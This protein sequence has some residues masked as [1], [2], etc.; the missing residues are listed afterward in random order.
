LQSIDHHVRLYLET[1]DQRHLEMAQRLRE[2]LLCLKG[3]IAEK[4]ATQ[5]R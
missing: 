3:W 2:Y 1:G 4:E 5:G